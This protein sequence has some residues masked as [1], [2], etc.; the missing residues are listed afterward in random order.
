MDTGGK[1][2]SDEPQLVSGGGVVK[3]LYLITYE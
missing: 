2:E 3:P 1:I